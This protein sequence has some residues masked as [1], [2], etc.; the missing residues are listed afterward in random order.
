MCTN[1]LTW[2][3]EK[4]VKCLTKVNCYCCCHVDSVAV[5]LLLILMLHLVKQSHKLYIEHLQHRY[6]LIRDLTILILLMN[7]TKKKN[8]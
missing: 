4:P 3:F 8:Y 1:F 7:K 5:W 2:S 6:Y